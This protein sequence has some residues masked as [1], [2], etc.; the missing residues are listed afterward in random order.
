MDWA[1]KIS[2]LEDNRDLLYYLVVI[3]CKKINL[4]VYINSFE[5]CP[6]KMLNMNK[7]SLSQT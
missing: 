4:K 1:Y 5:V 7:R 6:D 3:V 2:A